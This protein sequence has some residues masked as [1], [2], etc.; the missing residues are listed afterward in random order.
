MCVSGD[1]TFSTGISVY[2]VVVQKAEEWRVG[3]PQSVRNGGARLS[4]AEQHL[5]LFQFHRREQVSMTTH[6][7]EIVKAYYI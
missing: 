3:E 7:L 5:L 6:G 2:G 4:A 1:G